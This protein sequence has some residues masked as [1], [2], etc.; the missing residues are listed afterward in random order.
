MTTVLLGI[1][2]VTT[3]AAIVL[4]VM[5]VVQA[6]RRSVPWGFVALLVPFASVVFAFTLLE[7]RRRL[8]LA[9]LLL[10]LALAA[11]ACWTAASMLTAKAYFDT[12]AKGEGMSQFES[13]KGSLD[14]VQDLQLPGRPDGKK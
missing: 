4:H 14:D 12:K 7:A 10:G 6:F 11:G 1:A 9:G 3:L 2:L 8:L 5:V 13:Q